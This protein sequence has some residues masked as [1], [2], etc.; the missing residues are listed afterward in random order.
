MC[1]PPV[2]TSRLTPHS[3]LRRS[4]VSQNRETNAQKRGSF[5][6]AGA[7]YRP[8]TDQPAFLHLSL[9]VP[10]YHSPPQ[11]NVLRSAP[12]DDVP[13]SLAG[14]C[15]CCTLNQVTAGGSDP[16]SGYCRTI[17]RCYC[18]CPNLNQV[19]VGSYTLN[20]VTVRG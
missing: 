15:R 13:S 7:E 12:S 1:P 20:Q 6:S 5:P 14:Y 19:T 4:V 2:T 8:C 16:E 17:H 11:T 10:R 9:H 18:R 3:S